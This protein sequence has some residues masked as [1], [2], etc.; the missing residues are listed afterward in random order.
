MDKKISKTPDAVIDVISETISA[1]IYFV[2][3]LKIA[4][5]N[6]KAIWKVLGIDLAVIT[7]RKCTFRGRKAME[8]L[9]TKN[10][11]IEYVK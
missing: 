2:A 8:E 1:V 7:V 3:A 9:A 11:S 10:D 5:S 6:L 4:D